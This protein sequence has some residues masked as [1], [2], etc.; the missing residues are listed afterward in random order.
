MKDSK[1]E[2]LREKPL[3][4]VFFP[5]DQILDNEQYASFEIRTD[6]RPSALISLCSGFRRSS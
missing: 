2:S 5:A 4:Q 6:Q 1:Y 3:V